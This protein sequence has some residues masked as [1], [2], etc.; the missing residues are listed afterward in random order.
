LPVSIKTR[1]KV[2]N[3]DILDFLKYMEGLDIKAIMIHGR[4]F[5]QGFSGPVDC[6]II[7]QARK[8]FSGIIIA[9]GGVGLNLTPSPFSLPA[10]RQAS[11]ERGAKEYCDWLLEKT[12]ADGVGI[13]QGA[14]GRPWIFREIKTSPPASLLIRREEANEVSGVRCIFKIALKHAKLTEK[15]KGKQGIVEMRKHLCWYVRGL[16][17][18][19]KLRE[20]LVKVESL[21]EIKKIL[22][23]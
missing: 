10:D 22:S 20:K 15:L 1:A 16:T 8:Y 18:A 3:V 19:K 13:G 9:N 2:G 5:S 23:I 21:E 6:E 17:E 14:M 12:G 7:K 11:Q 4:T